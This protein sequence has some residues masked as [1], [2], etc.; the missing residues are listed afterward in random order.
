[1]Y[2]IPK[3]VALAAVLLSCGL[4]WP[5]SA[6]LSAEQKAIYDAGYAKG[7]ESGRKS[8]F[9]FNDGRPGST[10]GVPIFSPPKPPGSNPC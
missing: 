3:Q 2:A 9:A 5:A 1:M 6:Q 4:H 10:S 7:E 8:C